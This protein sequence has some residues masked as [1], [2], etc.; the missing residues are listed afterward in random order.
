MM[1]I[2]DGGTRRDCGGLESV[3]VATRYTETKTRTRIEKYVR[4]RT[5][6]RIPDT[7]DECRSYLGTLR[8]VD[9]GTLQECP[10]YF[11]TS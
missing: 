4:S 10:P 1:G 8:S 7:H 5:D 11:P 9:K 6:I 2:R 3:C